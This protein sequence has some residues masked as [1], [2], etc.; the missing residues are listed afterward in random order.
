M[1][2]GSPLSNIVGSRL[3]QIVGIDAGGNPIIVQ[4]PQPRL[5][6]QAMTEARELLLGVGDVS[7]GGVTFSVVGQS[8]TFIT[9]P[10][11]PFRPSRFV[12]PDDNAALF[13][14]D[15]FKIGKNSQFLSSSPVPGAVFSQLAVGV[16]LGLDTCSIGQQITVTVTFAKLPA[17]DTPS[18]RFLSA[19]IGTSIQ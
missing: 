11:L 2:A 6:E 5:M 18:V 7:D 9:Q 14:V 8:A 17:G 4:T 13:N 16:A 10:Q 1:Y 3:Q 12:I 19:V 15:D